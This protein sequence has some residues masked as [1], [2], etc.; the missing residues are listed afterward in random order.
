MVQRTVPDG[1]PAHTLTVIDR[2]ALGPTHSSTGCDE[3][4]G[5]DNPSE[6][7]VVASLDRAIFRY[8]VLAVCQ[9]V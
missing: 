5:D 4:R 7:F 3:R 9:P 1:T 2:T 8:D 6:S